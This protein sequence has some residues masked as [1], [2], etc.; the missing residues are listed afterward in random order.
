MNRCD[1]YVSSLRDRYHGLYAS[2]YSDQSDFFNELLQN[3]L[4]SRVFL[5]ESI[6]ALLLI[7]AKL[8]LWNSGMRDYHELL[9]ASLLDVLISELP[10]DA[11]SLYSVHARHIYVHDSKPVG[12]LTFSYSLLALHDGLF[13]THSLVN[14]DAIL[15][16]NHGGNNTQ[17]IHSI[18]NNQNWSYITSNLAWSSPWQSMGRFISSIIRYAVLL[19]HLITYRWKDILLICAIRYHDCL[20]ILLVFGLDGLVFQWAHDWLVRCHYLHINWLLLHL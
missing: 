11:R 2:Q 9:L 10:N 4:A 16:F 18:I 12:F 19:F 5:K 1:S 13:A 7:V 15:W 17:R 14:T 6:K 3:I 20:G 8:I